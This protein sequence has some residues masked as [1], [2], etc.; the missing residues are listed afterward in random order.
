MA[1]PRLW[2]IGG[3]SE[4]RQ[5][6]EK[7]LAQGFSLVVTV[8]TPIARHLYPVHPRLTVRVGPL[9]A[10]HIWRFLQTENIQAIVDASHPFAVQI[11]QLAAETA[12]Q[13]R[14]PYLRFERPLLAATDQTVDVPD[15]ATL[16]QGEY[17]HQKRV[18]L[19]LGAHWLPH[20][21]A[22]HTQ[23]VLFA[24]ILPH[25]ESLQTAIGAGFSPDRL[26]ALRPPISDALE[27]AL[28]QHWRIEVV[29]TKASGSAGGE[30]RKQA[31]AQ[32]LGI[33]LVRI[34]R[35]Q[36]VMGQTTHDIKQIY[37]FCQNHL[38]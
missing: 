2:L 5:L 13:Q 1:T 37:Q 12:Q 19:T 18:L 20:F 23:A 35:P 36:P 25:P 26:I 14:L 8:T 32:E 16:Q 4:S 22:L 31:L 30:A 17:L 15:L 3:T 34:A 28:W 33:L 24:R 38:T 27:R 6:T 21:Q 9:T 7:L 11:S 10:Q 29:I